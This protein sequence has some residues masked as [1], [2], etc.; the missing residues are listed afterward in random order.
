MSYRTPPS[1]R[2]GAAGPHLRYELVDGAGHFLPEEA[3][4]AV[5]AALLG[6]LRD[7]PADP[8]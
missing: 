1:H 4:D 5:T 2:T 7:L 6:W 3:P 8:V